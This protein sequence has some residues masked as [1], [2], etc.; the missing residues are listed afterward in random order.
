MSTPVI[1][2]PAKNLGWCNRTLCGTIDDGRRLLERYEVQV[3]C[4][5]QDDLTKE[6]LLRPIYCLR[7]L[8]EEIQVYASRMEAALSDHREFEATKKEY[9]KMKKE[10]KENKKPEK[11][12]TGDEVKVLAKR[13]LEQ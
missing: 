7:S 9:D 13:V 4:L 11:E 8:L 2:Q 12:M 10:L 6:D 3:M 5:V 1:H